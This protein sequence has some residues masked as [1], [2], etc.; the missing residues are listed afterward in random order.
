MKKINNETLDQ[1]LNIQKS[2]QDIPCWDFCVCIATF[3]ISII[4]LAVPS[5]LPEK[6]VCILQDNNRFHC[7]QPTF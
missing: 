3:V 1:K 5:A 4:F 7:F 6:Y 2:Q